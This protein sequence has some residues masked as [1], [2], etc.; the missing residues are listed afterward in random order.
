MQKRRLWRQGT[1]RAA[2]P[3]HSRLLLQHR[4]TQTSEQASRSCVQGVARGATQWAAAAASC[5]PANAHL[6]PRAGEPPQEPRQR[7]AALAVSRRRIATR[8]WLW[9]VRKS[10]LK[11]GRAGGGRRS[12]FAGVETIRQ[13]LD[14]STISSRAI[15]SSG[16]GRIRNPTPP[17]PASLAPMLQYHDACMIV[18]SC[19]RAVSPLLPGP[20][21]DSVLQCNANETTGIKE[22]NQVQVW[23]RLDGSG[24]APTTAAALSLSRSRVCPLPATASAA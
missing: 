13:T 11:R 21:V 10:R 17:G 19:T 24:A 14:R 8:S 18:V 16:R 20:S 1:S 4:G 9:Q 3:W 15:V 12:S 23:L 22:A 2:A 6:R 7:V 5:T